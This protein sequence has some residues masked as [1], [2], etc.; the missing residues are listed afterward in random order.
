MID[1][2]S[3]DDEEILSLDDLEIPPQFNFHSPEL[4]G[5]MVYS[6]NM[7]NIL[8]DLMKMASTSTLTLLITGT[9]GSGKELAA[10]Y[11]HYEV[12]Q[13]QGEYIAVN[14]TN[15]NREMF[16]SELFGYIGGAFT[17]ASEKGHDGYL[18]KAEKG[19]LFLDEIS[20]I[21]LDIQTKL[22]RVLE[23]GEYY[24]LGSSKKETVDCRMIFASNRN[25]EKMLENGQLRKDLYYRLNVVKIDIPP[26][27]QRREEIIPLLSFFVKQLN[28]DFQKDVRYI[29]GKVFKFMYLYNWPGNI[30]ELKNFITQ[31]MIFIEGDTI[32]FEHLQTK[33]ELDRIHTQ[34]FFNKMNLISRS[35]S[36]L[37]D[38]LLSK[39]FDLEEFSRDI[40]REA[41]KRFNGNK[42]KTARYL[43][44]KREQLYNRY[45]I[46]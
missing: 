29:Q 22:L 5:F 37:I 25:L 28:N 10:K 32:R 31:V 23:E 38:E 3:I 17:G 18:K 24:K 27:E 19:T 39:P 46:D 44:L 30:R 26:L 33:D 2:L 21:D 1:P 45:K 14:C 34:S 36:D 12:D 40:V 6:E 11:M 13:N 7:K 4:Q 16:E 35:R 42:S 8:R 15:M 43:G 20:E 41:L 9:T